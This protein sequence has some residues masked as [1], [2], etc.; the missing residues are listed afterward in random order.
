[1]SAIEQTGGKSSTGKIIGFIGCG[2]LGVILVGV[3]VIGLIFW[4][5]G[6]ALKSAEP[7]RDSIAAVEGNAAAAEALGTPIKPG[8]MPSG[9]FNFSNG[10]GKV[11]F[12]IPVSGPKGK[13]TLRVV[14]S[15]P[16]G[17]SSWTYETW[18]LDVQGGDSIPLGQ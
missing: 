3:A 15:K 18:Q 10:E 17:A 2:C 6:K 4:G 8:F 13:G 5:A 16:A 9:N 14:G 11:D 12:S 1:M 7:Y